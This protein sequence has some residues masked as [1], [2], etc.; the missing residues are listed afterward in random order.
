MISAPGIKMIW[1]L[2]GAVTLFVIAIDDWFR[3]R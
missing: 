2:A 1:M 3:R